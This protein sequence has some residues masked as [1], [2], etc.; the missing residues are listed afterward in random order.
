M[1]KR[2]I[3]V[4]LFF[5]IAPYVQ[6]KNDFE[7]LGEAVTLPPI[8]PVTQIIQKAVTETG[9]AVTDTVKTVADGQP[10]GDFAKTAAPIIEKTAQEAGNAVT[11]TIK[12]VV[13]G[14]PHGDFAKNISKS[15]DDTKK[16]TE[17]AGENIAIAVTTSG[18]FME[19]QIQSFGDTLTEAE[20]QIKEGK[21]VDA[22]WSVSTNHFKNTEKNL[23]KAVTESSLLNDVATATASIYGG[24]QGAA[25]YAAWITYKRTENLELALKA[26]LIAGVTAKGLKMVNGMPR[27]TDSEMMKKTLASASIGGAAVA[28]S[29][30]GE[31]EVIEAFAKGAAFTA[32]REKYKSMTNKEIEGKITTQDAV[33]KEDPKFIHQ[34][35][36]VL[37]EYKILVDGDGNPIL[38]Q[39]GNQQIDIRSM[40]REMFHVGLQT[41]NPDAGVFSGAETSKPMQALAKVPYI[42]DMAYYHVQWMALTQKQGIAVQATIIPAT[43]IT[44][45]GSDTPIIN[46]ATKK[47]IDSKEKNRTAKKSLSNINC[48]RRF[49]RTVAGCMMMKELRWPFCVISGSP[50]E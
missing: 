40:P 41:A 25:A 44:V 24:P 19:N 34:K 8:P 29:G 37:H 49:D 50:F 9:N 22:I 33:A 10:H 20:K 42:N 27:G 28:A 3:F 30:G 4:S 14:R 35:V 46:Q 7:R 6:A 36:N 47:N 43:I 16:E 12:T 48:S 38:D 5:V 11:D 1:K 13:D 26:G 23:N 45:T 32:A 39:H 17:R 2:N 18:H 31:K 15:M 21:L